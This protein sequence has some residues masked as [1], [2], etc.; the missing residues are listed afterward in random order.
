MKYR[1]LAPLLA[2]A[3]LASLL[4]LPSVLAGPAADSIA[5]LEAHVDNLEARVTALEATPPPTPAPTPTPTVAPTP[6]PTPSPT[7]APTPTPVPTPSPTP[8]SAC[9][10]TFTGDATGATDVSSSLSSFLNAN[11]TKTVCLAQGGEYKVNGQ[12]H[13]TSPNGLVVLGR[14]AQIHQSTRGTNPILLID[15]GGSG[16]ELHDL[17]VLG[18]NPTPGKWVYAYEHN[19]GIAFGGTQDVLVESVTVKNVGGDGL[20]LSGGANQWMN[21]VTI[22]SNTFD[23]IGRMGLAFTDG[24]EHA[25]VDS[26]RWDNIAYYLWDFEPNGATVGGRAAGANDVVFK[27]NSIGVKH[28]G[29]YPADQTQACGYDAV[30]TNASG[31]GPIT[32]IEGFGNVVDAGGPAFRLGN[33][34]NASPWNWHDNPGQT[35]AGPC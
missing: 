12:V 27:N 25:V 19:H 15:G 24:V 6:T 2:V 22:Y 16:L 28:Y 34:A 10:A 21:G 5:A 29:D 8:V 1:S 33:F 35:T 13:V 3:L 7:P 9:Q 30:T 4:P 31:G 11:D 32:N 23:G 14:N 18:A 17:T 20:Y 26:N